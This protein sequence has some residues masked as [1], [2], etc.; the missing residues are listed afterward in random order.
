MLTSIIGNILIIVVIKKTKEFT[1]SQYVYKKSIAISDIIWTLS[2]CMRF[3]Y[4][5]YYYKNSF[6]LLI[7]FTFS[8]PLLR[9]SLKV[10][11]ILL[12]FAAADRYF[13][14]AF[15][16]RYRSTNTIKFAKTS[17]TVIWILSAF[18]SIFTV[19]Y[20]FIKSKSATY[21]LQPVY[22]K[23]TYDYINNPNQIFVSVLVFS[24]LSL[25]W[26]LT[27]LTLVSLY[28]TY[29]RSLKLTLRNRKKISS[30]K[31]MSIVL[32][33]MVLAFTFSLSPTL[34]NH[35]LIYMK[36]E[37]FSDVNPLIAISFLLTNPV[38]NVL[39]YSVLNKRFRTAFK[40]M[41]RKT[42]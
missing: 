1:H 25:L 18:L 29:K 41:F 5:A 3:I 6:I 37:D 15:P 4:F 26:L 27:L 38:W 39:I 9:V 19:I 13:A 10:S 21:L 34:Y 28:I 33:F 22:K 12:I 7:L 23:D 30:E 16:L 32:I 20:S 11:L 2:V 35:V 42:N 24:L 40:A 8:K 14:L 31:Q 36:S 17:S